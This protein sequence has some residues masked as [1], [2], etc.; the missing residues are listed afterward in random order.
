MDTSPQI[1]TTGV[2]APKLKALAWLVALLLVAGCAESGAG[3][4]A[5]GSQ[6][7]PATVLPSPTVVQVPTS[8]WEVIEGTDTLTGTPI[9]MATTEAVAVE[10]VLARNYGNRPTLHL[11]CENRSPRISVWF[12]GTLIFEDIREG[13]IPVAFRFGDGPLV[14]QK[15]NDDPSDQ[16]AVLPLRHHRDFVNGVKQEGRLILRAWSQGDSEIGTVTFDLT[17]AKQDVEP[18][19][20][21]CG[22]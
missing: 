1:D 6:P 7:P 15:W 4:T 16:L 3:E 10:Y 18:V 14:E 8:T 5:S 11:I 22:Y 9:V 19:L 2:T 17:G 20:Q 21:E 12:G 13:G